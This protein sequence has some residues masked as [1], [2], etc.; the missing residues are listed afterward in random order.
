MVRIHSLHKWLWG[1][2]LAAPPQGWVEIDSLWQSWNWFESNH[3][4]KGI[5]AKLLPFLIERWQSGKTGI[6]CD[7]GALTV[8]WAVSVD[9]PNRGSSPLIATNLKSNYLK[10]VRFETDDW[11]WCKG[12]QRNGVYG[13]NVERG[14]RI[15]VRIHSNQQRRCLISKIFL[16]IKITYSLKRFDVTNFCNF[17][18][19]LCLVYIWQWTRDQE[20]N[21]EDYGFESHTETLYCGLK[22]WWTYR[23][24]K[25]NEGSFDSATRY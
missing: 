1:H 25:P 5:G 9:I 18:W 15:M 19:L 16:T 23:S 10:T 24:H 12:A 8:S 11:L 13:I 14:L 4:Y 17:N 22:F 21:P 20:T 6:Y 7:A 3:N 2:W